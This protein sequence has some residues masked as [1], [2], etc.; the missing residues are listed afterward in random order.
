MLGVIQYYYISLTYKLMCQVSTF[1]QKKKEKVI[2][3][4]IY[5][6]V[7]VPPITFIAMSVLAFSFFMAILLLLSFCCKSIFLIFYRI[8]LLYLRIRRLKVGPLGEVI[9]RQSCPQFFSERLISELE[10]AS[11]QYKY[12]TLFANIEY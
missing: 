2:E 3:K 7:N 1:K 8:L 11:F 10:R 6:V 4:M 9:G 12:L 5:Y